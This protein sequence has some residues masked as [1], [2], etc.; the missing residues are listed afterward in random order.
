[1]RSR[2][3]RRSPASAAPSP[4]ASRSPTPSAAPTP[5]SGT[6]PRVTPTSPAW[7]R[8]SRRPR[9]DGT[10]L[11][12]GHVGD[13]RAYLLREDRLDRL[14]MDHSLVEELIREGK[15]TE[16]QAAVHPQRSIITRA[17]GVDSSVDVD[18]YSVVLQPTRPRDPLLGRAHVDGAPGGDRRHPAERVRP[19][20]GCE[21]PGR[22]GERRGRRRQHHRGR[23]R[24]PGRRSGSAA[25]LG[26]R[27]H[28]GGPGTRCRLGSTGR[29]PSPRRP[30]WSSHRT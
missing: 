21:R 18:V 22:R 7:E 19:D 30:R 11:T 8:P 27:R 15:I 28:H 10:T 16:E 26:R 23:A 29:P 6:R 24:R 14:T 2:A 5:R 13:S 17:L 12:I 25:G 3:P 4:T 9:F 20:R 1:M